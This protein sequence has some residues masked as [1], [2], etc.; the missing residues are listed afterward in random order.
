MR[1]ILTMCLLLASVTQ[2]AWSAECN[3]IV[4]DYKFVAGDVK[5]SSVVE[6]TKAEA[7]LTAKAGKTL[8]AMAEAKPDPVV[9]Q[10]NTYRAELALKDILSERVPMFFKDKTLIF[11]A[12]SNSEALVLQ[13][14]LKMCL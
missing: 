7:V 12:S 14:Q 8:A 1:R 3:V 10:I 6:A 2:P 11:P 13:Q 9:I 5:S 4:G